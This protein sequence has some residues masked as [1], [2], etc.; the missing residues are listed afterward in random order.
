MKKHEGAM[1]I[2]AAHLKRI[3]GELIAA[4]EAATAASHRRLRVVIDNTVG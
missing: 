2:V 3:V 4:P 1:G